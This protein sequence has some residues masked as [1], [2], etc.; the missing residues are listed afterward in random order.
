VNQRPLFGA[1]GL[2]AET[3]IPRM[4]PLVTSPI[5]VESNRRQS[6]KIQDCAAREIADIINKS[7][8]DRNTSPFGVTYRNSELRLA[9][10]RHAPRAGLPDL[11]RNV[12]NRP[13]A[14]IS[15]VQSCRSAKSSGCGSVC[16][17]PIVKPHRNHS[18][19][20]RPSAG[21]SAS[22][23]PASK[24]GNRSPSAPSEQTEVD[25]R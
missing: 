24:F 20:K 7:P 18:W 14:D 21:L 1:V 22:F 23:K 12:R 11:A 19:N 15:V 13:E 10:S 4:R 16:F 17:R 2:A 3:I 6:S 25:R 5:A 9:D 8:N